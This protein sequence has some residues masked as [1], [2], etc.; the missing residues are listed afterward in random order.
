MKTVEKEVEVDVSI[1]SALRSLSITQLT[2]LG[3]MPMAKPAAMVSMLGPSPTSS[4]SPASCYWLCRE[5]GDN[6]QS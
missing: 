4:L 6:S 2:T 1:S 5:S 3:R